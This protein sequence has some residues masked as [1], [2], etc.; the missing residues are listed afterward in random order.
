[1]TPL[2]YFLCR[3]LSSTLCQFLAQKEYTPLHLAAQSGHLK[4]VELLLVACADKDAKSN[5]RSPWP[6][7]LG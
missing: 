2:L 5:V 7:N 6:F 4:V 3:T 1:M